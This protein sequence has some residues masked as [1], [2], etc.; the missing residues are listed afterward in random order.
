MEKQFFKAVI[1]HTVIAEDK[2]ETSVNK[3]VLILAVN[4]TDAEVKINKYAEEWTLKNFALK[5]LK[6]SEV[7]K[8]VTTREDLEKSV[9]DL[10][11][12]RAKCYFEM[13][14]GNGKTKKIYEYYLIEESDL[15]HAIEQIESQLKDTKVDR[16]ETTKIEEIIY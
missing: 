13:D 1:N 5:S 10:K 7:V 14:K 9:E 12:I 3:E 6:K 8:V 16:I 15:I 4:Y 11:F 2:T